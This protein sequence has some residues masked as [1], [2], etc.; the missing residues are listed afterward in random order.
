MRKENF[1]E[2]LGVSPDASQKEI[3]KK[4]NEQL[5]KWSY[6][7]N[8]PTMERRQEAEKMLAKLEKIKEVLL[9][10]EKRRRYDRG[11]GREKGIVIVQEVETEREQ[12]SLPTPP[13]SSQQDQPQEQ[14]EL[15]KKKKQWFL[16]K[17]IKQSP[18]WI[19][20]FSVVLIMVFS[21]I[22]WNL[23]FADKET[24]TEMS[25]KAVAQEIKTLAQKGRVAGIQA[26]VGDFVSKIEQEVGKPDGSMGQARTWRSKSGYSFYERD[27]KII[28]LVV[29]EAEDGAESGSSKYLGLPARYKNMSIKHIEEV[30]GKPTVKTSIN[31]FGSLVDVY[32]YQ[33]NE[34]IAIDFIVGE[35]KVIYFRVGDHQRFFGES[36]DEI[37]NQT[38]LKAMLGRSLVREIKEYAELGKVYD[39]PFGIGATVEEVRKVWGEPMSGKLAEGEFNYYFNRAIALDICDQKVCR[40]KA[41]QWHSF[42]ADTLPKRY[43]LLT[44]EQVKEV[45]G[46]NYIEKEDQYSLYIYQLKNYE[47]TFA[48]ERVGMDSEIRY[49]SINKPSL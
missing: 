38:Q 31:Y 47:L 35:N 39:M 19:G 2:I 41:I 10:E 8:A 16:I 5:R 9:D 36:P 32:Y 6:R 11:L 28:A 40:I 24:S 7:L 49:F 33:L 12:V 3:E 17:L 29:G 18:W 23:F 42:E 25:G 34:K 1:Y 4:L 46:K 27:K 20:S 43:E 21:F 13:S 48:V 26:G 30:F 14:H 45:L 15:Y 37:S 44:F 22:G